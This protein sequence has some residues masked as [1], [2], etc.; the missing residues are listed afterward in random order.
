MIQRG[1]D[2][3]ELAKDFF[4]LSPD[5]L[6]DPWLLPDINKVVDRLEKAIKD[7]EQEVISLMD[8]IAGMQ[9]KLNEINKCLPKDKYRKKHFLDEGVVIDQIW[10]DSKPSLKK[11]EKTKVKKVSKKTKDKKYNASCNISRWTWDKII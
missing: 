5:K 2:T 9:L 1:I 3:P 8:K 10:N 6:H 7:Q 11:A 4:D